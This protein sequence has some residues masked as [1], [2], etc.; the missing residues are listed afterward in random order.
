MFSPSVLHRHFS[1]F[2]RFEINF[3]YSQAIL[4]LLSNTDFIESH[5]LDGFINM[6]DWL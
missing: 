6:H 5:L 1:S 2:L 3:F 4:V